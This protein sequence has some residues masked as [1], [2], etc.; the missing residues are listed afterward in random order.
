[1]NG[2]AP[3]LQ[4]CAAV[5]V[6]LLTLSGPTALGAQAA[7]HAARSGPP[8]FDTS[9]VRLRPLYH[10]DDLAAIYRAYGA[11]KGEFETTA[12]FQRRVTNAP[13]PR[14]FAFLLEDSSSVTGAWA[15][16]LSTQ[17]NADAAELTMHLQAECQGGEE[18]GGNMGELIARSSF[19]SNASRLDDAPDY[20]L[21][22]SC[23]GGEIDISYP[24]HLEPGAAQRT[25]GNIGMVLVGE[26]ALLPEGGYTRLE[27]SG[28][29]HGLHITPLSLWIVNTST[30]EVL[31]KRPFTRVGR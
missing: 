28:D 14:P 27:D 6:L 12:Q 21:L 2:P 24:V 8:A 30:G 17:Y 15:Y 4:T 20:N 13:S 9:L 5:S 25:Q 10:G 11:P 18:D 29:L 16:D 26:P 22:V 1:M 23:P 7:A 3:T 31:S 19:A